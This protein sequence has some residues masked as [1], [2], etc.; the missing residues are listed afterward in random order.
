M[1][2]T[3]SSHF[4][5]VCWSSVRNAAPETLAGIT[6][7]YCETLINLLCRDINETV[8]LRKIIQAVEL[9]D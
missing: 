4:T 6:V 2:T 7:G 3:A 5:D 1:A 9:P 8:A